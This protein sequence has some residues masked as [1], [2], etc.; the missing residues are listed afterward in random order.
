[1]G[2]TAFLDGEFVPLDE[3][4]VGITTHA[5]NYGTNVFEGIRAYWNADAEQLFLFRPTEHYSRFHLSA[6]FYGMDPRYS[7]EDLSGIT[8]RLLAED[9]VR[10]D[11]YIRPLLFKSTAGIGLWRAGLED[12]CAIFHVP[13]GK[14]IADGG[15]RCCVS[16]WRRPDGNVAPARAKIGGTYASMALARCEAMAHGFDEALMLTAEGKVGEGTGENIFLVQ[17]GILVTPCSG[18]DLLAGITRSCIIELA[19]KEL[20]CNVVERSVNRSELYASDE[21]FLCGTAAEVTPVVDIDHHV[22]GD[23]DGDGDGEVGPVTAA[24][25]SLY[26]DVVHGRVREYL[27]WCVPV[28][29]DEEAP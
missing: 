25:R 8:A 22:I 2:V 15:I 1:V 11:V 27:D 12:S 21:I 20:G 24:V 9:R 4:K 3:V 19:R 17:N 28:Y 29:V 5:F 6:G 23:G 18:D 7:P 14:Y 26:A 10:E 16:S 13:M